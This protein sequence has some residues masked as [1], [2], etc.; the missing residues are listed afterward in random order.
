[1]EPAEVAG[2]TSTRD[3]TFRQRAYAAIEAHGEALVA[4]YLANGGGWQEWHLVRSPTELDALL[5]SGAQRSVFDVY[6]VPQLPIR[7]VADDSSRAAVLSA[8]RA[9]GEVALALPPHSNERSMLVHLGT[10]LDRIG[11]DEEADILEWFR[12]HA[13]ELILA[14][15]DPTLEKNHAVVLS[16]R[17]PDADGKIRRAAF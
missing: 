14:G 7:G 1:V 13:G 8:L 3:P 15:E 11:A 9:V 4:Y 12:A 2:A 16:A 10:Y 6:S 17:V 5:E